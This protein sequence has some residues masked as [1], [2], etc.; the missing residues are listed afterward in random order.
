M[1]N[2]GDETAEGRAAVDE[3]RDASHAV[4]PD[5]RVGGSGP[6]NADF[7]DA[8][9]GAFP[10]MIAL[11]SLLTF[12]L[13]AR[14]FRSLLLPLKAVILNILSVGAAWGVMALVWQSGHGSDEIWGIAATGS[15]ASWIPLMVFAFLYGLSM[16][17]EVFILSRMR[18][19][20]DKGGDTDKAVIEGLSR[21][22][23][24][25]TS[26]ALIL[27]L[28]FASMASGPET[29]VKILAT[30]LAAGILLDATVVRALLVPAV[31]S[32]F[33]RWN[34]WLPPG[35]AKLLRVKPSPEPATE[36]GRLVAA[37][38]ALAAGVLGQVVGQLRR[39]RGR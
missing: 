10:L 26:A 20:F 39:P 11:I 23:R 32:M 13:L 30:G 33:G 36:P 14:A 4:G 34:W 38:L 37:G 18:E 29:D 1:P 21:T 22:G 3:V 12:L 2:E 7:I 8:V 16:D 9:Y 25:V 19:E 24:L 6:L 28:A 35:P 27:F 5:V 15:I 31:V 17:Y